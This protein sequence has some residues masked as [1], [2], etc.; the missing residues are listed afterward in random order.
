MRLILILLPAAMLWTALAAPAA[1]QPRSAARPEFRGVWVATVANIDWPSKKG[2]TAAAQ[3]AELKAILDKCVDVKLNAVILQVRPMADALYKSDLEPWS[4]FLTGTAGRDP[5]YDPLEFAVR[6][7]HARG[8]ELHAWLNPYRAWAP[9]CK[10]PVPAN[11]IVKTRPDLAKEYGEY[12]WLNP[13]HKDVQEHSLKVFLDVVRRYDVD[14]IHMDD[15][16][17]PYPEYGKGAPFPDDDTWQAYQKSG[18][19]LNRDDWRRAAVNDFVERLY[20]MTKALKPWVKVGISPFG[21]WRPGHPEGIK[22]FDQYEKLYAD[23]K[24]WLNRGWVDYFTP[25][26]YWAI[27]KKEQSFPKL[28]EWWV[29]EDTQHR[30][31]WPGM[32][33]RHSPKE[34]VEQ[35]KI[36]RQMSDPPGTIFFS[37]KAIMHREELANALKE[38]Y[39]QPAPVPKMQWLKERAK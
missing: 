33:A 39:A 15:Y 5:G 9:S 6:E 20:K 36:T 4:E 18:G 16:F 19:T 27:E 25:Q 11:H 37:M 24:L 13:T 17:Y 29:S 32:S 7:A 23:A 34:I 35:I 3:Q 31:V 2:L 21:I 8:L 28:L 38:V 30:D 22:G 1:D 14:G 12:R 10:S 26:L